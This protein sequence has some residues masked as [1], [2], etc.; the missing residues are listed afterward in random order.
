MKND[1]LIYGLVAVVF[2]CMMTIAL[3]LAIHANIKWKAQ[4][5]QLE[6]DVHILQEEGYKEER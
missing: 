3:G 6:E 2:M 1:R 4:I 5:E